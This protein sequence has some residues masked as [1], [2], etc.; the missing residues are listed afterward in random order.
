MEFSFEDSL[1]ETKSD[2]DERKKKIESQSKYV[3]KQ[4]IYE[5]FCETSVREDSSLEDCIAFTHTADL[6]YFRQQYEEALK[7]YK[8]LLECK[9]FKGNNPIKRELHE[10]VIRCCLK[11]GKNNEALEYLEPL[12]ILH[13]NNN[14]CSINILACSVYNV[15]GLLEKAVYQA[16]IAVNVN[17]MHPKLW[18]NLFD[19]LLLLLG[20]NEAYVEVENEKC[21]ITDELMFSLLAQAKFLVNESLRGLNNEKAS[22]YKPIYEEIEEKMNLVVAR[23]PSLNKISVDETDCPVLNVHE[24]IQSNQSLSL[25]SF[26]WTWFKKNAKDRNL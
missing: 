26:I 20:H 1:F 12:F 21:S 3:P 14:D 13:G 4:C 15:N 8:Q 25:D 22:Q 19:I 6:A 10:N 23:S 2:K 11:L 17:Q 7:K 24:G 16:M 18:L 5:W 9:V